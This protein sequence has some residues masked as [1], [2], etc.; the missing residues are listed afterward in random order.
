MILA[1]VFAAMSGC[2]LRVHPWERTERPKEGMKVKFPSG[3][4]P[5]KVIGVGG[6]YIGFGA[7][8]DQDLPCND[9]LDAVYEAGMSITVG[10]AY[11]NNPLPRRYQCD[12]QASDLFDELST[13]TFGERQVYGCVVRMSNGNV[14]FWVTA[15][16]DRWGGGVLQE[17]TAGLLTND[18]RLSEDLGTFKAMLR[19]I[20]IAYP[21]PSLATSR[22]P[23]P[24][25]G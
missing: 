5:C 2:D 12:D 21:A 19:T 13:L 9:K 24:A 17:Y 8:L 18:A 25:Y 7:T 6:N 1:T 20:E 3:V 4:R 10:T 11:R 22:S 14:H 15:F 23:Q 16:G